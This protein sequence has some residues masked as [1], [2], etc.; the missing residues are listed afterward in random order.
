MVRTGKVVHA[1]TYIRPERALTK[2]LSMNSDL[3]RSFLTIISAA[4][5][6]YRVVQ[7]KHRGIWRTIE[8]YIA[9]T[10]TTTKL[11]CVYG[12]CRDV[13]PNSSPG[14][15]VRWQFFRIDELEAVEMTYYQFRPHIE[16]N[17]SCGRIQPI[18][19]RLDPYSA[20]M[21]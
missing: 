7:L 13:I 2:N 9:G 4:I 5:V 21:R 17:G 3:Q 1:L 15:D 20:V 19:T 16:Y 14:H 6:G 18:L 12:F 11:P 8:P 10:D